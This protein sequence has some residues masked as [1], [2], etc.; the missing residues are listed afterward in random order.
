MIKTGT[1]NLFGKSLG[2]LSNINGQPIFK[3]YVGWSYWNSP[4]TNGEIILELI[5]IIWAFIAA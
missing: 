3:N 5:C 1:R 4:V 2:C